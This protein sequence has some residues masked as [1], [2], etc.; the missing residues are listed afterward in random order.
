MK[1]V[2]ALGM[3]TMLFSGECLFRKNINLFDHQS[4]YPRYQESD[5][6]FYS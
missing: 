5:S 3:S 1:F 2:Y 6:D 4:T